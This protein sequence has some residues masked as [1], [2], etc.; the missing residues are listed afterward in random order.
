M[1]ALPIINIHIFAHSRE[2]VGLLSV[3]SS[4]TGRD[5]RR[6]RPLAPSSHVVYAINSQHACHGQ[7]IDETVVIESRRR[8]QILT[9]RH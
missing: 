4:Q 3:R 9:A 6:H 1:F 2:V 7:L 5:Y 8:T